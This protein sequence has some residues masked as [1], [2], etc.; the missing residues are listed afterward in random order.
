MTQG[1]LGWK[2]TPKELRTVQVHVKS[3][4]GVSGHGCSENS[5]KSRAHACRLKDK[6]RQAGRG[7][8]SEAYRPLTRA[9]LLSNLVRMS[10]FM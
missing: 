5:R 10:L 9:D 3:G 2:A 6:E 8:E 7:E 4:K 1:R